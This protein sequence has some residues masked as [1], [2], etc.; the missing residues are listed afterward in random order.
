MSRSRNW[1]FT[2]N[3]S[4]DSD[5][6]WEK[7]DEIFQD[8]ENKQCIKYCIMGFECGKKKERY[9]I[10]GY[11]DLHDA[12]TMSALKKY[13]NMKEIHLEQRMG[14]WNEAVNY[15]KKDNEFKFWGEE[16]K[17]GD[18][19]DHRTIKDAFEDDRSTIK[20]LVSD[21]IIKNMQQLSFAERIRGMFVEPEERIPEVYWFWGESG[22]GKTRTAL[23]MCPA[24]D[25][26]ISGRDLKWWQGYWGQKYV[27]IDDFRGDFCKFHE[28]LRILDRYPFEVEIKGGSVALEATTIIITC[29]YRPEEAYKNNSDE[30]NKQLVRRIKEIRK[31]EISKEEVLLK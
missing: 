8:W 20:E 13:L 3:L 1:C 24:N 15:C 31:F 7:Y 27:I 17:Q 28:L 9:H 10:Q 29:P 25:R 26:W 22:T 14:T 23:S 5:E 21:G 4:E 30:D 11:L 6:S 2:I 19:K 16:N 18:R 12:K